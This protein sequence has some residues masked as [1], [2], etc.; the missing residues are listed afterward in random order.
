MRDSP[1]GF[2]ARLAQALPTIA[3]GLA[4]VASIS[5]QKFQPEAASTPTRVS[6]SS[7]SSSTQSRQPIFNIVGRNDSNQLA[8]AIQG[9]FNQPLKAYVVSKEI[10]SQQQLDLN[11]QSSASI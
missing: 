2:F 6:S 5:R 10:T 7:G 1:G 4:Q 3:F 9:Q 8:D 11:I